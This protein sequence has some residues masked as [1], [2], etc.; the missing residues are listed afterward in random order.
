MTKYLSNRSSNVAAALGT[1][2]VKDW[3]EYRQLKSDALL[4]RVTGHTQSQVQQL[5]ET[6]FG[7]LFKRFLMLVQVGVSTFIQH[8]II[9][10]HMIQSPVEKLDK[11][12]EMS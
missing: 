12:T 2:R 1:G 7:S 9:C 5:E 11:V 3:T 4:Q 8:Q 10:C 6:Y